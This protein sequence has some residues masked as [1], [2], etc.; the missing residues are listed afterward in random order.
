MRVVF[1]NLHCNGLILRNLDAILVNKKVPCRHRFILN[2]MLENPDIEIIDFVTLKGSCLPYE[3]GKI[4]NLYF[5]DIKW[6]VREAEFVFRS[7]NIKGVK[8]ISDINKLSLTDDDIVIYY[9]HLIE[10]GI[11]ECIPTNAIRIVDLTHFNGIRS[12]ML[13]LQ[14]GG[15]DCFVSEVNLNKY[16][17]LYKKNF[18]Y[19]NKDIIIRPFE[20]EKRFIPKVDFNARKNK[21]CA[22]GSIVWLQSDADIDYDYIIEYHTRYMQISRKNI[23]DHSKE[24]QDVLDCYSYLTSDFQNND[25]LSADARDMFV[26]RK[27]KKW[28]NYFILHRFSPYYRNF[29]MVDKLNEYKIVVNGEDANGIYAIGA[30]EAMACGCAFVGS[31]YGAFEDLG[32]KDGES[33]IAYNGSI[34]NLKEKLEYYL[35]PANSNELY[36]IAKNGCEYVRKNFSEESIAK[37]YIQELFKIHELRKKRR[38]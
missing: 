31:N 5:S 13:Q 14:Q 32:L 16:S 10:N 35:L 11:E 9:S 29:D 26:R 34:S 17:K 36:N 2:A 24:L 20:Y 38:D 7:N 15:V 1:V 37:K 4:R 8:I 18:A 25:I 19:M 3:L 27:F 21:A 33:Y 12:T 22:M 28:Y 6:R 23:Y 30:I